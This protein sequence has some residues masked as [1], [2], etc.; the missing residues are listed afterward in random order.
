MQ[1]DLK[2]A[3]R[4]L[5]KSPGFLC[6]AVIT[7]AL[8]IGANTA[9]FSLVYS[10]TLRPLPFPQQDRLA[11]IGYS[12][13]NA[14]FFPKGWVRAL[15]EHSQAFTAISGFS[16][17]AEANV[18]EADSSDRVFTAEVMTN[19]FDTLGV[20]PV[21][22]R[23]FTPE[24]G[25]AGRDQGVV[26]SYGY[27]Q[28]RFAGD[29]GVLGKTLR[30][31]GMERRII[32][33]MPSGV[34]FPYA[35][36]Q[37]V[38]PVAFKGGDPV[39]PWR[40][41]NLYAFGRLQ[42]GVTPAQ[43]Q[44]E[45]RKL[46]GVLLPL[47]PWRMPDIWASQ[48][49]V[50]SL[51]E[52]QVGATRPR[53][54]LLFAAVGLILLIACANVANLMLARAAGRQREM[55]V[56]G[57]LGASS[58]RL[59]RQLL[60][61]SVIL[62]AL[63]GAAGLLV[64]SASLRSLLRL[65][66][67]DTPRV[68]DVSLQ[69]P[70]FAFAAA[71]SVLTGFV[72][73][74]FP[75]LRMASPD[76]QNVLRSGGRGVTGKGSQFR[77]SMLLV[78]GQIGLSV[79]VVIVAGLMLRS[80]YT[81]GKVDPGFR[82]E[83]VVTGEVSLNAAACHPEGKCRQFF[84]T[85][86]NDLR[87]SSEIESVAV[88]DSLPLSGPQ[89]NYVFDAESHPRDPHQ[90]ALLATG[91]IVSPEYFATLGIHL[92]RGRLLTEQDA[93]G[94]SHA[95]VINQGMAERLW[96]HQDPV[97]RHVTDVND[98]LSPGVWNPKTASVIVGVAGNTHEGSLANDYGDE[99]YLPLSDAHEEPMMY[100]MLR[101]RAGAAQ[102]AAILRRSVAKLDPL[103]PV[104]RVR[105]LDDVVATTVSAPRS[106]AILLL[107]FAALALLI[108]AIGV[109]S[110]IAYIVSWRT[111]EIGIKLALGAGRWQ[112][113]RGIVRQSMAL[114]MGGAM[115]GLAAA[116]LVTGFLRSFLFG[117]S[118]LDPLT[119]FTVPLVALL[120]AVFAAWMPARRAANLDPMHTLRNE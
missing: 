7:L 18:T 60:S 42:K 90:G 30:V 44:A 83:R 16:A 50:V 4:Q 40:D 61:E 32:G 113:V 38:T 65:L 70:V 72:F 55:A 103:V 52:S 105:S 94:A 19:A 25:V 62:G 51:L 3:F 27:W 21:L 67:A 99:L 89:D 6:T 1:N 54:L 100:V 56:R 116:A 112:I 11:R 78:M 120:L 12:T 118:V 82:S 23:F 96:P 109:Y 33:V 63:S 73:G 86:L 24:D 68:N 74:L 93:G 17:D 69:W 79:V 102:A 95:V 91:R 53:L 80:L 110:L 88:T 98:E 92:L 115:A 10:I 13:G 22:G 47:F 49:T 29:P 75:A 26:L 104:T 35:D 45:M 87:G 71:L 43:A 117:I 108:G 59:I 8:G 101:T 20:H 58:V 31:D 15:G 28:Q 77:L 107:A 84:A 14:S 57:A 9:I 97:G 64:A 76:L 114:A 39:D 46:Q 34:R 111:R 36:T 66:P 41:F 37:F 81:L 2:F 85:L 106:L 48:V 5:R 119:F